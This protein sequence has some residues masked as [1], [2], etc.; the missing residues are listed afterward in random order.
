MRFLKLFGSIAKL[1]V[2]CAPNITS[3]TDIISNA[4][5][6][7]GALPNRTIIAD[8]ATAKA[9]TNQIAATIIF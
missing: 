2:R 3:S 8:D 9:I 5:D 4:D 6:K 7:N 1:W